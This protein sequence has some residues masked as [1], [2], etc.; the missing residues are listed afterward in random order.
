MERHDFPQD[1]LFFP[2]GVPG[3]AAPAGAIQFTP[4]MYNLLLQMQ[5]AAGLPPGREVDGVNRGAWNETEDDLLAKAVS[6]FGPKK[7]TDI[8]KLVPNRT[9]KQCRERW[10]NKLAPSVKH[11]PF[12]QWEDQV[13]IEKQREIGNRWATIARQLPGRSPNSVKNRWYSGLKS[14]HEPFAHLSGVPGGDYGQ[15]L[16]PELIANAGF[17]KPEYKDD[18]QLGSGL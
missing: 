5:H 12:E 2:S 18:S 14:M 7:W 1:P 16:Y 9:S 13:I 8:A 4:D 3:S 17:A 15:A 10:C 11:E 6:Q